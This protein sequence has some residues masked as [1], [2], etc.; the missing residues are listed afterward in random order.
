MG[1]YSEMDI[2]SYDRPAQTIAEI[3]SKVRKA[4]RESPNKQ[5][6]VF[7]DYLTLIKPADKNANTH[8]QVGQI[9]KDLKTIAREFN[10][11]VICL[12]QLSRKVEERNEKRPMLS[13]L[14]E[15]GSIEQDA[16]IV[17]LLYRD[18]YY[19]DNKS[20]DKTLE[21]NIAKNRG[22]H[23]NSLHKLLPYYRSDKKCK[24]LNNYYWMPYITMKLKWLMY[25][26]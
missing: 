10:V 5:V 19:D 25:C 23:W 8:V 16:D 7:I 9:S 6:V 20:D 22:I 17:I 13:D 21:L 2:I 14:R 12:A 18:S 11:P 24:Q 1:Q 26:I 15:S 3:R 4:V